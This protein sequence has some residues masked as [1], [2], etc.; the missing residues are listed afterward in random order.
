MHLSKELL[1]FIPI[2]LR[3]T[4][5][6]KMNLRFLGKRLR[7]ALALAICCGL[8]G[9]SLARENADFLYPAE[10]RGFM[11]GQVREDVSDPEFPLFSTLL[12][13]AVILCGLIATGL[14]I[15]RKGSILP[16]RRSRENR[17]KL[18]ETRMLG[19]RQFL[20]VVEYENQKML[21]GIG[22]GTIEHLCYLEMPTP[23]GEVGQSRYAEE[24]HEK[25]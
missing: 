20:V 16:I 22:P 3:G 15:S 19:H 9:H 12:V 14:H 25:A 4:R 7:C 17:L 24:F 23:E 8:G 21:L 13:G 5:N 6:K 10:T 1:D 2:P 11:Q 18:C